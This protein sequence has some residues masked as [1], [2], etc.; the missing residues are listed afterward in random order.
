M[1][2]F[3]K[4]LFHLKQ[5]LDPE[6]KDYINSLKKATD[7]SRATYINSIWDAYPSEVIDISTYISPREGAP[8]ADKKNIQKRKV[9]T[10]T[11][12]QM[13]EF[14]VSN[15]LI[16]ACVDTKTKQVSSL[17]WEILKKDTSYL[18]QG[19]I[20]KKD[21]EQQANIFQLLY[22]PN[23]FDE[24][25]QNLVTKVLTDLLIYDAGVIRKIYD[26]KSGKPIELRTLD[27]RK[28]RYIINKNKE[29][30]GFWN[31]ETE[32]AYTEKEI[33]YL[34]LYPSTNNLYGTPVLESVVPELTGDIL[35]LL[36]NN[37]YFS[38]NEIPDGLLYLG[39]V[40]GMNYERIKS[41]FREYKAKQYA[42]RMMAGKTEPKWINFRASNKDMQFVELQDKL[43]KRIMTV[44]QINDTE[45]G[46][47]D[48]I[49][50]AAGEMQRKIF[51]NKGIRPLITL[52]EYHINTEFIQEINPE[53][54]FQFKRTEY[55][56]DE[57]QYKQLVVQSDLMK[58]QLFN[59]IYMDGKINLNE[60]RTLCASLP[61]ISQI[62]NLSELDFGDT[63]IVTSS[64]YTGLKESVLN[65]LRQINNTKPQ[66]AL[67][68]T[69]RGTNSLDMG[70]S[71]FE[72][73][74]QNIVQNKQEEDT[75]PSALKE[76]NKQDTNKQQKTKKTSFNLQTK[77]EN[78]S[79]KLAKLPELPQ[80]EMK[81]AR[82]KIKRKK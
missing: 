54:Y 4:G 23:T 39:D 63:H 25:F 51:D 67:K 20:S 32:E 1:N 37:K 68:Q 61:T 21:K 82:I 64:A 43:R 28:I 75:Q 76:T 13:W 3:Q 73:M 58:V 44:F 24:S 22:N 27:A 26:P 15:S 8:K 65:N 17:D 49:N 10:L 5:T 11:Y 56:K 18:L 60:Y 57:E 12:E 7:N 33:I 36:Y 66:E 55:L 16:R 71:D 78:P 6:F 77:A 70:Y 45:L 42:I 81:S 69:L 59:L 47:T 52:L 14:Y 62:L 35:S 29:P 48:E 40:D 74:V 31:V 38:E 72:G 9:K 2:I 53:F 30:I 79:T 19:N 41:G 80:K 50:K 34:K 46:Y